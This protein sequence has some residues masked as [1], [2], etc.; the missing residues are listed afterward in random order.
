MGAKTSVGLS[1]QKLGVYSD[2]TP[3]ISELTPEVRSTQYNLEPFCNHQEL[4][5]IA[6]N[7]SETFEV[8]QSHSKSSRAIRS[9][10]EL[11]SYGV[12]VV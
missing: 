10:P 11:E 9:H 12:G 8:V 2:P 4:S 1:W 5:G 6:L 7:H 3:K